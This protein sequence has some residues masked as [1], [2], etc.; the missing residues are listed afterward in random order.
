MTLPPMIWHETFE[1]ILIELHFF[2]NKN[3][4]EKTCIPVYSGNDIR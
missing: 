4:T 1:D 3:D 2:S